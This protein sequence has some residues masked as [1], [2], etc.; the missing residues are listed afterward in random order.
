MHNRLDSYNYIGIE[1]RLLDA[2]GN[3]T[4]IGIELGC[5]AVQQA[6]HFY[7]GTEFRLS[8]CAMGWPVLHQDRVLAIR[9]CN[10]GW[11]VLHAYN[12]ISG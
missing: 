1:F 7:I 5:L 6:G 2:P 3:K 10:T 4:T 11:Q 8:G 9:L 12:I